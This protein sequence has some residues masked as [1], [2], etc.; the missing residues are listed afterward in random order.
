[1][2]DTTPLKVFLNREQL[3]GK[4]Q[5]ASTL[6]QKINAGG[7]LP[8]DARDLKGNPLWLA[9]RVARARK[10][11]AFVKAGNAVRTLKW[12]DHKIDE[13]AAER[14]RDRRRW[15]ELNHWSA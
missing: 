7:F 2:N 14:A 15:V 8:P 4:C 9:E 13:E 3:A 6:I 12:I 1:M 10:L 11:V 5:C